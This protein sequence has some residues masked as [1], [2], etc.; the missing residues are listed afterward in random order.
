MK[1]SSDFLKK[2]IIPLLPI[3]NT[4]AFKHLTSISMTLTEIQKEKYLFNA[5]SFWNTFYKTKTIMNICPTVLTKGSILIRPYVVDDL[6]IITHIN[7]NDFLVIQEETND[8]LITHLL[9]KKTNTTYTLTLLFNFKSYLDYFIHKY[10]INIFKI[11][12]I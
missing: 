7:T 8:V 11:D 2:N 6:K 1:Y 12:R 3:K 10:Y 9:V 5:N 4:N